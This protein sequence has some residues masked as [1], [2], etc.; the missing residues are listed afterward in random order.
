V[1]LGRGSGSKDPPRRGGRGV[2]GV[3]RAGRFDQEE[4]RFLESDGLM[5]HTAWHDE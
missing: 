5:L 2:T 3:R 1:V 4:V